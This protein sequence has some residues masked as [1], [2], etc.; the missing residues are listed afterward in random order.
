[1]AS[2]E[3]LIDQSRLMPALS[4]AEPR[5]YLQ[6]YAVYIYSIRGLA[7]RRSYTR[8]GGQVYMGSRRLAPYLGRTIVPA[9]ELPNKKFT[10][11]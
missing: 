10:R 2:E 6:I 11:R 9:R 3:D 1:M 4:L 7:F 8:R 5:G